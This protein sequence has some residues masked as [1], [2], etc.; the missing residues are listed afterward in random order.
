MQYIVGH[1]RGPEPKFYKKNRKANPVYLE[2]GHD[3]LTDSK[4]YQMMDTQELWRDRYTADRAVGRR[5]VTKLPEMSKSENQSI[6]SM[7]QQNF[8]KSTKKDATKYSN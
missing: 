4:Q 3:R 1:M 2:V 8:T 6:M 7:S 5:F